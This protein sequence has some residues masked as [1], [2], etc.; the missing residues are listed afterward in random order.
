MLIYKKKRYV[1]VFF[2]IFSKSIYG[3]TNEDILCFQLIS[4][5][6]GPLFMSFSRSKVTN[7]TTKFL[8]DNEDNTLD[9]LTS[10]YR[11]GFR[12]EIEDI[13]KYMLASNWIIMAK[14]HF[15]SRIYK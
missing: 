9:V 3:L 11:M 6:A 15:F 10:V 8:H 5:I 14:G 1:V 7:G 4:D 2:L 12:K 13:L